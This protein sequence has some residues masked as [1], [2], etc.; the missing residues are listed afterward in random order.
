MPEVPF[1]ATQPALGFVCHSSLANI[2]FILWNIQFNSQC[3]KYRDRQKHRT[4]KKQKRTIKGC[5]SRWYHLNPALAIKAVSVPLKKGLC[6]FLQQF[7]VKPLK[8]QSTKTSMGGEKGQGSDAHAVCQYLEPSLQSEWCKKI[9]CYPIP[10]EKHAR[11][12]LCASQPYLPH[13]IYW[14]I[15]N[16]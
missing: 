8:Y 4:T 15:W 16:Q 11:G 9:I 7:A 1:L 13:G 2:Q 5:Y 12:Y 6:R 3:H 14:E 10:D